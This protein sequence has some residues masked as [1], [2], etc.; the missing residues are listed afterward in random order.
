MRIRQ[1]SITLANRAYAR[2]PLAQRVPWLMSRAITIGRS[3]L[4]AGLF[5]RSHAPTHILIHKT[6]REQWNPEGD[7]AISRGLSEAT[8]P[9]SK[10]KKIATPEGSQSFLRGLG[11][12]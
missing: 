10:P 11:Y 8:P 5:Y 1:V 6:L 4:S 9:D 2:E 3:A 12:H 7:Q